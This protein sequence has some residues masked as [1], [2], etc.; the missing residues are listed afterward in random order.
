MQGMSERQYTA[1]CGLSR[2]G[3]QKAK[4]TGRLAIHG[5]G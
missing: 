1:H 5:D 4:A 2:T 3:V